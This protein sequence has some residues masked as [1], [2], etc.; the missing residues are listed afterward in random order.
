MRLFVHRNLQN[1]F[2]PR[3][4]TNMPQIPPPEFARVSPS[5]RDT[6]IHTVLFTL[7][8][9]ASD[10]SSGKDDGRGFTFPRAGYSLP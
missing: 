2:F 3:D 1:R 10:S 5:A 7:R 4:T 9:L 6:A 8:N